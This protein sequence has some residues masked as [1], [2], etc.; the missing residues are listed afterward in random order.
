[1]HGLSMVDSLRL[2][3]QDNSIAGVFGGPLMAWAMDTAKKG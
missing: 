3:V 2:P 1:M